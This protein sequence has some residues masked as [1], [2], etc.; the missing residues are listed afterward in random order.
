MDEEIGF[1]IWLARGIAAA[2]SNP[3]QEIEPYEQPNESP[4]PERAEQRSKD[5]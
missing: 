5:S 1:Y 4:M 2:N 3:P